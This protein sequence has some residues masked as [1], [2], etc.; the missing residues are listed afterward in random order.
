MSPNLL[1][2]QFVTDL[3]VKAYAEPD[4]NASS[5]VPR[6][7]ANTDETGFVQICGWISYGRPFILTPVPKN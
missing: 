6:A 4:W 7:I 3:I 5:A 1:L 2:A